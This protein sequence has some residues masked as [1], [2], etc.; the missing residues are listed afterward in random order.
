MLCLET[1]MLPLTREIIR[2]R[3]VSLFCIFVSMYFFPVRLIAHNYFFFSQVRL[4]LAFVRCLESHI[5]RL[6]SELNVK[7]AREI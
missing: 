2:L 6:V 4:L 3:H 1:R 7:F 5:T